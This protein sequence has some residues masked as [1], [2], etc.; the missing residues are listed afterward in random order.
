MI[1]KKADLIVQEALKRGDYLPSK[2]C[3]IKVEIGLK[4]FEILESRWEAK[5]KEESI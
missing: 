1:D 2:V 5:R 4:L 3:E